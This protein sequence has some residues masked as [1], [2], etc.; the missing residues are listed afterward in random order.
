MKRDPTS[1]QHLPDTAAVTLAGVS[2]LSRDISFPVFALKFF[3]D[4]KLFFLNDVSEGQYFM[5]LADTVRDTVN[6]SPASIP[7]S[8][9]RLLQ[10]HDL[11]NVAS[12]AMLL[13]DT[14]LSDYWAPRLLSVRENNGHIYEFIRIRS[15]GHVYDLPGHDGDSSL[16]MNQF[17]FMEVDRK[18]AFYIDQNDLLRERISCT[19]D[20]SAEPS[21]EK[22]VVKLQKGQTGSPQTTNPLFATLSMHA[23]STFRFEKFEVPQLPDF[24]G[25][26]GRGYQNTHGPI[27]SGY[28]MPKGLP[29]LYQTTGVGY[30]DYCERLTG[31]SCTKL[32][33]S[34]FNNYFMS[35]FRVVGSNVLVVY[36]SRGTDYVA[37]IDQRTGEVLFKRRLLGE[38]LVDSILFINDSE[39]VGL[40]KDGMQ[41]LRWRI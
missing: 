32:L 22:L 16:L 28:Q 17:D 24:Y 34:A 25:E 6:V 10:R 19:I 14:S 15:L 26:V 38:P 3:V 4:E 30:S 23:D 1:L 18:H 39:L 33:Y 2:P 41:L 9:R 36:Q 40:S 11:G 13:N 29:V 20:D 8:Y 21:G 5:A 35:D 12:E 27:H 7:L 31:L 37:G